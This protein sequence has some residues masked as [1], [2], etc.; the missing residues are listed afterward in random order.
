MTRKWSGQYGPFWH[1]DI[2]IVHSKAKPDD[3]VGVLGDDIDNIPDSKVHGAN[4]GST[5]ALS[6]PDGPHVSPMNLVIR[7]KRDYPV[8]GKVRID[9]TKV[10]MY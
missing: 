6:A 2:R 5:W 7:D 1:P 4:M 10:K 8:L 9:Q 3:N